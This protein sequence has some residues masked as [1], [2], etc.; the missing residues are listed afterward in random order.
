MTTTAIS[1]KNKVVRYDLPSVGARGRCV[2]RS[3]SKVSENQTFSVYGGCMCELS[4]KQIDR[5]RKLR[6]Q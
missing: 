6:S 1:S 3:W 4:R 5:L 2:A